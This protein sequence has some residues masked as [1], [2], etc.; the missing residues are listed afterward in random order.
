MSR[1]NI[2]SYIAFFSL[3]VAFA[4]APGKAERLFKKKDFI[5][6]AQLYEEALTLNNRKKLL[7]RLS[8]CYYNTYQYEKGLSTLKS[9][10]DG[11]YHEK[12]KKVEPRFHFMY[13]QL[14]SATGDYE[15]A[16]E[17]LLVYRKKMKQEPLNFEKTIKTVENLRLKKMDFEIKTTSLNS[18]ASDFAAIMHNDTVYFSSDRGKT[19]VLEKNYEWTHRPFLNLYAVG[20]DSLNEPSED[21]KPL[22]KTINS[23]LH[24]GSF[25]FSKDGKTLYFSRSNLVD[26]KRIFTDDGKNQIQLYKSQLLNG[27]WLEPEKLSFCNN[28]FNYQHPALSKNGRKL[29]YASDA[30]GTLGD[31]D[32]FYVDIKEDDTYGVPINIG[33]TI[34]TVDR[35]QYPHISEEGHLLF[36]SNGHVGVGLLDIFA[37]ET[38]GNTFS[39]PVNLGAPINSPYDDFSLAYISKKEGYFSSNRNG[40]DDIFSFEQISNFFSR[41]YVNSFKIQ[42]SL[43][44]KPVANISVTLKNSNDKLVYKNILG[45]DGAFTANLLPGTY[46]ILMSTPGFQEKASVIEIVEQTNAEHVL[47]LKKLFNTE[48]YSDTK[49]VSAASKNVITKLFEDKTPPR[50][51]I[52]NGK[53]YLDVPYI[54]FDF[55]R[56]EIREESKILLNNLIYKLT[57]YPSIKIRINS[58]TDSRGSSGYNKLLSEKRGQSTRDYIVEIG[59]IKSERVSFKGYGE[60]KLLV[61]CK[62]NCT[63]K[64]HQLNRRS[65]FEI[66]EY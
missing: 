57:Q 53:F 5:N 34:N 9:I 56:W 40:N 22:P 20:L 17:Q 1:K 46:S 2:I 61:D 19:G 6:A 26:G 33:N 51:K 21:P 32:I 41:E 37:S 66:I 48:V 44:G 39:T 30:P 7:E 16:I 62:D 35:E 29:Y 49:L 52:E 18:S 11:N 63:E 47:L 42:D 50:V 58:H 54:Y 8:D 31:F 13:Y 12:D 23:N 15:Q 27:K 28:D 36:A 10:I 38:E 43:S 4:Q 14:L 3:V 59:G 65:Q 24:E 45:K 25:T 55:D 60:S 64:N